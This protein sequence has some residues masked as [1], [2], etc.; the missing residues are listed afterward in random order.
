MSYLRSVARF[1][2]LLAER[3]QTTKLPGTPLLNVNF[4]DLDIADIKGVK[5]AGL[6]HHSDLNSA[7]EG[8]G[9]KSGLFAI[10]HA[11]LWVNSVEEEHDGKRASYLLNH[12]EMSGQAH[13]KSDIGGAIRGYITITPLNPFLNDRLPFSALENLVSGLMEQYKAGRAA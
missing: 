11:L 2:A 4:P 3:M 5:V 10:F 1:T 6:A 7:E 13:E 9:G 8:D 12:E